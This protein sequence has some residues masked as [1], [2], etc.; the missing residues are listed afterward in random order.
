MS[1]NRISREWL[2]EFRHF[3]TCTISNAIERM[4]V[5]LRNEGFIHGAVRCRFPEL[6]PVIGFAVTGR[7]RTSV[8]PVNGRWYHENIDFWRYVETIP[9]PRIIVLK[10]SDHAMGLGA[11]FGEIHARIC[12]ALDCVAFVTNG[13][14]RDLPGIRKVGIQLFA[15]NV[16]VSHAYAHVVDFGER[17]EIGGLR[18]APG[19]LLHGDLHGVQSIPLEI[20]GKLPRVAAEIMREEQELFRVCDSKDFSLDLLEAKIDQLETEVKH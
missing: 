4:K 10:D 15:G 3:D 17:V 6:P 19:D 9:S 1:E 14:V 18:I 16:S 20:A 5:R 2:E 13:A 7:L 8:A 12:R 11:L